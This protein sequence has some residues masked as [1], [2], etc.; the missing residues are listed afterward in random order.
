MN[1]PSLDEFT[2]AYLHQDFQ[3]DYEDEWA[4]LDRYV[5]D[6]PDDARRLPAEITE[7][8]ATFDSEAATEAY[9]DGMA[10]QYWADPATGGY[11]GWLQEVARRVEAALPPD[12]PG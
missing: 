12:Q 11:R 7:V 9:L 4:A 10:I 8:L 5:A 1:T 3:L 6:A 2:G